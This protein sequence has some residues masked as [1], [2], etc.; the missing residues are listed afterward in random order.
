MASNGNNRET[1]PAY[2]ELRQ[3]QNRLLADMV[4]LCS[5]AHPHYR[6]L[7]GRLGLE[8]GD[9]ETVEDLRKLPLLHKTE[10]V[11]DP[12]SFRLALDGMEGLGVEETTIADIIY[13]SGSTGRPTPFYDTVHDRFARIDHIGRGTEIVGVGESD[14]VMNLF[15]LTSAPHQGFLSATWGAAAVGAQLLSGLTG[16]RYAGFDVHRRLDDA[17]TM[18]ERQHVTVLW[19]ITSFVRRVVIRAQELGCDYRSVRLAMVMGEPCPAGMRDDMRS[20][21]ESIGAQAPVISNGYGFTEMQAPTM[22]CVEGGGRHVAAPEQVFFEVVDP[23]TEGPLPDGDPG[24]L[25]MSH[26][27]RRGTVLLRYRVGD[28]TAID[29]GTCP[30]CGRPGPRFIGDPYR[31]DSFVKIKGTL[32]NRAVLDECLSELL[33]V[34][35][36]SEYQVVVGREDAADPFSGDR[37]SLRVACTPQARVAVADSAPAM[38]VRAVEV[39]P[40]IEYLPADGFDQAASLYKF[41]R[42]IDERNANGENSA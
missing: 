17:V 24:M 32:V 29:H 23:E 37:L 2:P 38:V 15:P 31:A 35:G 7:F 16:R 13:T 3:I 18:I 14:I 36:V 33:S 28:I 22:E 26:L 8:P 4:R 27:N 12:E 30:H 6:D 25:V 1:G 5:I 9:I 41:R 42:F 39:T 20:R 19:G 10:F 21:L 34:D 40:E 11:Q